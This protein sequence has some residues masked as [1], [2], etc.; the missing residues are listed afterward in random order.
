MQNMST[1]IKTS[2]TDQRLPNLFRDLV[3]DIKICALAGESP[4]D[5]VKIEV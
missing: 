3:N 4:C 5:V 1:K 2:A